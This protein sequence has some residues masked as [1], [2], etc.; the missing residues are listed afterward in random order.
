MRRRGRDSR[1]KV[2]TDV[3]NDRTEWMVADGESRFWKK[4]MIEKTYSQPHA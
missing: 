3:E 2:S 1:D 4:K